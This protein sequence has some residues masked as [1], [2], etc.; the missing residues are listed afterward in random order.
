MTYLCLKFAL[1]ALELVVSVDVVAEGDS[2]VRGEGAQV[3][4]VDLGVIY[5]HHPDSKCHE[6]II[7]VIIHKYTGVFAIVQ[8]PFVVIIVVGVGLQKY[9]S[10]DPLPVGVSLACL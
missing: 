4:V 3:A 9:A 6:S 1:D 8:S 7:I 5:C 10:S 2:R